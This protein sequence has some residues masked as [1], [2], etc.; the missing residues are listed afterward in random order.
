MGYILFKK[1]ENTCCCLLNI[2]RY[3][4]FNFFIILMYGLHQINLLWYNK[5][6]FNLKQSGKIKTVI[7]SECM[8]SRNT[9]IRFIAFNLARFKIQ[10]TEKMYVCEI[11]NDNWVDRCNNSVKSFHAR[12]LDVGSMHSMLRECRHYDRFVVTVFRFRQSVQINDESIMENRTSCLL[13]N[14]QTTN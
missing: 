4:F 1:G 7:T 11:K 9:I 10:L 13:R 14:Q 2:F 12:F 5:P 3:W 8:M 6:Y